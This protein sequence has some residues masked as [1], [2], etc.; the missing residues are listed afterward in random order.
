MKAIELAEQGWNKRV[1]PMKVPRETRE[2]RPTR[3]G[4]RNDER[5][6]VPM[7]MIE[8]DYLQPSSSISA[9]WGRRRRVYR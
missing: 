4:S 7:L 3:D 2:R 1:K 6:A 8:L 9:S 5:Q